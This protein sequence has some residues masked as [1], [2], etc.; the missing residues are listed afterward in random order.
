MCLGS[1]RRA[2][3]ALLHGR[4][5]VEVCK[6]PTREQRQPKVL[7]DLAPFSPKAPP[8]VLSR[9]SSLSETVRPEVFKKASVAVT[10][11]FELL[12]HLLETPYALLGHGQRVSVRE[13]IY[14]L[15]LRTTRPVL[16]HDDVYPVAPAKWLFPDL[17]LAGG[18]PPV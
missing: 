6:K 3:L 17:D 15:A 1:D 12:N 16:C 4:R 8:R 2:M 13:P 14:Q 11:R 5:R 7:A 9:R 10:L 18:D